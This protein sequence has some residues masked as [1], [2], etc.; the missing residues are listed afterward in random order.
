[1]TV[2]D[3]VKT[4]PGPEGG[5]FN[6]VDGVSFE[7]QRGEVF[8]F[9]GPN[10]AGKTTTLEIIEGIKEP[11]SVGP[12][13]WAWTPAGTGKRSRIAS[14]SSSRRAYFGFLTLEEILG[15][16]GS[17][18]SRRLDPAALLDRVGLADKRSSFLR[19]LSGGQ[20][21][22]FSVVAAL[23]NDPEVVFLDE[24]TTGLDPHARRTVWDV[25]RAINRDQGKTVVLTTHYMEEPEVLS[26]R[27]AIFDH[28]RTR[29]APWASTCSAREAVEGGFSMSLFDALRRQHFQPI[30]VVAS[31]DSHRLPEGRGRPSDP[32]RRGARYDFGDYF[33]FGS[34]S[35]EVL[36]EGSCYSSSR[37]LSGPYMSFPSV[38]VNQQSSVMIP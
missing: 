31:D 26:D 21:R 35:P 19:H 36:E 34:G 9:L 18:Y 16:F 11:T 13:S 14:G 20:A 27:I 37:W 33:G 4:Y 12:P 17:F 8:G 10:G 5:T 22:R 6:A 7:V 28:G 30:Q 1:V 32:I 24:P 3:L 29:P 23:V 25:V 2:Q 38:M 15:L